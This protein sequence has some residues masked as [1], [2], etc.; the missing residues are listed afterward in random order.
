MAALATLAVGLWRRN[1]L[2][3]LGAGLGVL[4]LLEGLRRL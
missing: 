3:A 4:F 1:V 2:L